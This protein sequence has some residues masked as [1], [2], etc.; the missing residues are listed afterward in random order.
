[1]GGKVMRLWVTDSFER[2][3]TPAP[4]PHTHTHTH[5]TYTFNHAHTHTAIMHIFNHASST[6]LGQKVAADEDA[7]RCPGERKGQRGEQPPGGRGCLHRGPVI[8]RI[9]E[10]VASLYTLIGNLSHGEDQEG[11]NRHPKGLVE[12]GERLEGGGDG[13]SSV[14]MH[15]ITLALA[16]CT[17]WP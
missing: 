5:N 10:T 9:S 8:G 6:H 15:S 11:D 16:L 7:K 4:A 13:P 1:M 2:P 17:L 14:S 12:M 3:P